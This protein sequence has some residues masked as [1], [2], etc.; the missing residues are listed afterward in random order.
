MTPT[1]TT[2]AREALDAI[3]I[4]DIG[5]WVISSTAP[6]WVGAPGLSDSGGLFSRAHGDF[7][8]LDDVRMGMAAAVLATLAEG[9]TIDAARATCF[10]DVSLAD[11]CAWLASNPLRET[12][13]DVAL[14][15]GTYDGVH[16]MLSHAY[17]L[18][19]REVMHSV[20]DCLHA[21]LDHLK[22]VPTPPVTE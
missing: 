20:L 8:P 17:T 12:Y 3:Y 19:C 14:F 16:E 10:D 9:G 4:G 2:I 7:Q 21:R 15:A 5:L 1:L 13:A 11:L 6:D 18:E 22:E